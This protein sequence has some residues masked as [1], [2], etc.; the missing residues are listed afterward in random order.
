MTS[1]FENNDTA[2]P[3]TLP[4]LPIPSNTNANGVNNNGL[5]P[6]NLKKQRDALR[7]KARGEGGAA[8]LLT[9]GSVPSNAPSANLASSTLLG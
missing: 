4:P 6:E 7:S 5:N 9:G 2:P 8:A 1:L 3:S